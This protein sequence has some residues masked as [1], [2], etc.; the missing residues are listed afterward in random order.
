MNKPGSIIYILPLLILFSCKSE[1]RGPVFNAN[2]RSSFTAPST[3]LWQDQKLEMMI[4]FGLYSMLGGVY[5][6]QNISN[7][8]SEQIMA[9]APIPAEDYKKL[10]ASF[11]PTFWNAD[12]IVT[13][14]IRS[15]M[16][17]I[18]ITAKHHDGFC[19]YDTKVTDFNVVKATP[20]KRD[21]LK[22][23]SEACRKQGLSFGVYFSLI[24]WNA[25]QGAIRPSFNNADSIPDALHQNNLIQIKE[26]CNNYS[27]AEIWF[28]MGNLSKTQSKEIR[29]AVKSLQPDC[30]IGGR[31]GNGQGDFA[32]LG[33]NEASE[34]RMESPWQ[35]VNSIFDNTWG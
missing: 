34:Y 27:P 4:H 17:S 7:G 18:I 16:K 21:I 28:D 35:S 23:L 25:P 29:D 1:H 5:N 24:D 32:V 3:K 26:L 2:T 9:N 20:Y 12:S 14:A 10:A 15:G 33:D 19:L 22:D 13:L 30:M 8:Y 6:G 11:N 31:L